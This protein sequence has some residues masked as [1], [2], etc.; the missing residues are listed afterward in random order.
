MEGTHCTLQLHKPVTELCYISFYLPRGDVGGFSYKGTV[1][2]DRSNKGFQN[3]YQVREG[4][5]IVSFSQQ[6]NEQ[7][8]DIFFKQT[9]TKDILTE[10]YKLTAE[11]ERLLANL[12]NSDHI[13]GI[14]TGTQE[15]KLP[16]LPV[17]VARE[18]DDCFQS[19]GDQSGELPVGCLSKRSTHGN[20]KPQR[21]D[22]RRESSEALLQK[23][24]RRKGRGSQESAPQMGKDQICSSNPLPL[25]PARTNLRLLEERGNLVPNR[26]LAFSLQRKEGCPAD[27]ARTSHA[28][29]D[30]GSFRKA[31]EDTKL[32]REALPPDSSSTKTGDD[33]V[34]GQPRS[35]GELEPQQA[36]L[37]ENQEDGDKHPEA[38]WGKVGKVRSVERT[39]KK[40]TVSKV[41]AKVQEMPAQVQRIV[42]THS[43]GEGMIA[44]CPEAPG[45]FVPKVDLLILP[46][47]EVGAH[48]SRCQGKGQQGDRPLQSLPRE[49]V[50]ISSS[51]AS[52][53]GT[54]NK[55]LLKVIESEKLDEATVGK[56]LGFPFNARAT[57]TLPETRSQKRSELPRGG[58]KSL[59]LD[60][61]YIVG[62]DSSE[63]RGDERKPSPPAPAAPGMVFNNSSS[64]SSAHKWLSPVPSPLSP[65]HLSPQRHHRILRLPPL[66]DERDAA[67]N[68]CPTRNSSVFSGFP[69]T[70]TLEPPSSAKVTET[71]GA[72]PTSLRA[73]QPWL[74]PGEPSE[75]TLGTG[76]TTAQSEHQSPPG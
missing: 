8:G 52:T 68:Y 10:L 62:P 9:P 49:S 27:V 36:S 37:P 54:V 25:S 48:G 14:S 35:L 32:G 61:L 20:R 7:I 19:A 66:P 28:D 2:L 31:S 53:E 70:D 22:G 59:S 74:V 11:R 5:D 73:G 38:E 42:R 4:S 13:L 39:C 34:Q 16:E 76:K 67:L 46:G 50:S 72:N 71:K 40:K 18:E 33:G 21:S 3:C 58:H 60:L 24:T 47:A 55:V 41:V 64:Q 51:P 15:G 30:L 56:R 63:P 75:K 44:I 65:R 26:A 6:P 12:L 29:L 45:E 43:E 69:S 1:T 23:R 17:S 57:H